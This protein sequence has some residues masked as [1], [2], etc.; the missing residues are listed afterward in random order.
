MKTRIAFVIF[1]LFLVSF[2]Q[3]QIKFR[4]K[5]LNADSLAALIPEK[6]GSELAEVLNLLSNVICRKDIDSSISLSSRAIV[7]SEKLEYKKGLADGY[8]NVGNGYYLL[9]SLRPAISNYLKAL[10]IYEDIEPSVEYG[11]LCMQLM[12][13]NYYA[14]RGE[15]NQHYLETAKSIF[16]KIGDNGDK[17]MIY[18]SQGVGKNVQQYPEPDSVIY[19]CNI[20]KTFI[21]TAVE[22]NELA[23]I[24]SEI[25]EA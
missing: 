16:D 11:Y 5:N 4:V 1:I 20:A 7:L 24:Y 2:T 12:V 21:D 25:G 10:R 19:Y 15:K 17:Y 3:G 18:F 9:D 14:G 22:Q 8:F 6:E 13:M 23:Y